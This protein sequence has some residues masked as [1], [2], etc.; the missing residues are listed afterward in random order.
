MKRKRGLKRYYRNLKLQNDLD[1]RKIDFNSLNAWFDNS[2][3]HFDW[4][5]YGNNSFKRRKPHLDKLFRHFDLLVDKTKELKSA[6]QLYA[7]LLDFDSSN[8]ALFLHTPNPNN[9]QFPFK[10]ENLSKTST[11]TNKALN[12]Y[13]KSVHGYEILYGQAD[14]AFCLL[15]K[16]NI[17]QPF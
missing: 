17:G 9:S 7:V 10:F 3:W 6:F 15:Y 8:D 13:I 4:K 16:T 11:L 1:K 12:G 2:H 5:G 14:E